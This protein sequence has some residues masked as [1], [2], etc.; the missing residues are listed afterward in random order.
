MLKIH[1]LF[2]W[3]LGP[4]LISVEMVNYLSK[5][6]LEIVLIVCATD[7]FYCNIVN[8]FDSESHF[9]EKTLLARCSTLISEN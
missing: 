3:L 5:S 2:A 1:K 9:V 6:I 7:A 8:A 4:L